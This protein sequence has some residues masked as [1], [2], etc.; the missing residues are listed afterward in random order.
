MLLYMVIFTIN[1]Y[2]YIYNM[3]F[4]CGNIYDKYIIYIYPKCWHIYIYHTWILWAMTRTQVR[5][6]EVVQWG[7]LSQ[8]ATGGAILTDT[9][10]PKCSY[11]PTSHWA[12][13]DDPFINQGFG[14]GSRMFVL[15]RERKNNNALIW[16][17][18]RMSL[19]WAQKKTF[20][21]LTTFRRLRSPHLQMDQDV[22]GL[23]ERARLPL[24]TIS[25]GQSSI[26]SLVI[27]YIAIENTPFIDDLPINS[28]VMFHSYVK[29]HKKW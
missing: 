19:V 13:F 25:H 11:V 29:S 2:I 15:S 18:H 26:Y 8:V 9:W 23:I 21:F 10:S 3:F 1:I 16:E 28:M 14:I 5:Y 27:C 17:L 24:P 20:V 7:K 22:C 12:G 6:I 4:L